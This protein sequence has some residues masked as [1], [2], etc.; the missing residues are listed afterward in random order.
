MTIICLSPAHRAA[1]V[2]FCE[3]AR[4]RWGMRWALCRNTA[5]NRERYGRCVRR[6]EYKAARIEWYEQRQSGRAFLGLPREP[7]PMEMRGILPA[8]VA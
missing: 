4:D 2:T 1:E 3:F 7:E 5:R 8:Q 6:S